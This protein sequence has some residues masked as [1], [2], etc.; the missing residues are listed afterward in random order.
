MFSENKATL[1]PIQYL[2]WFCYILNV[3]GQ[4]LFDNFVEKTGV[5]HERSK[6]TLMELDFLKISLKMY[7]KWDPN[8]GGTNEEKTPKIKF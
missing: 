1:H 2:L 6:T 7:P 5:D 3:W 4:L 8:G